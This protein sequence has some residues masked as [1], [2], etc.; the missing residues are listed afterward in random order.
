MLSTYF[1][2]IMK[3]LFIGIPMECENARVIVNAW[4][5]EPSLNLNRLSW[6]KF[7][8]WHI[9]LAFLGALPETTIDLLSTILDSAFDNCPAYS[10]VL[11]GLGVFP[12]KRNPKVLWLGL[13]NIQPLLPGYQKLTAL[14]LQNNIAFDSKPLKAHLTIAR[15]K[16]LLFPEAFYSLLQNNHNTH[17]GDVPI[18]RVILYESISSPSGVM[19]QPLHEKNLKRE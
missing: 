18:T 2:Y 16:S 8:N 1:N 9:T 11:N 14:L 5:S 6:T 7:S 13:D 3:R 17:F 19:Y 4:Q 10:T 12:E 15:V